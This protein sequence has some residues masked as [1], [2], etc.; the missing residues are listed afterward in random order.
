MTKQC[1]KVDW[2]NY[3]TL[4]VLWIA[5]SQCYCNVYEIIML[6]ISAP[7]TKLDSHVAG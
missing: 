3:T 1:F 4:K 5:H 7:G 2:L 6:A